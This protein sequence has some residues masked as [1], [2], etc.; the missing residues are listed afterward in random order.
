MVVRLTRK[1][2]ASAKTSVPLPQSLHRTALLWSKRDVSCRRQ[3]GWMSAAHR[4][5]HN[6]GASMQLELQHV[7][8]HADPHDVIVAQLRD[9]APRCAEVSVTPSTPPQPAALPQPASE[10]PV[11]AAPLND[12][13]GEI[14]N[15][16]PRTG[17]ARGVA[18]LIVCAGIAAAAVWNS[19]GDEAKQ[20]LSHLVPLFTGTPASTQNADTAESQ[21][22]T[23][24]ITAPQPAAAPV[25]DIATAASTATSQPAT[26]PATPTAETAL[27]QAA[28]TPELAQSIVTMAREITALKQT[29]EQL[30]AGQQQLSRDV[31]KLAEHEARR[32]SAAQVSKPAPPPQ[33]QRTSTQTAVTR[34]VQPASAQA[35]PQ[36]PAY[37]QTAAQREAYVSPPAPMQLPPQPGDTS[38]PRPP[39]PLR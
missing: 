26:A 24:Q 19:Y 13:A 16:A 32:K 12:N 3:I 23:S 25:Q 17:F 4:T 15:P 8:P 22:A 35:S 2:Y 30:Q 1:N 31:A 39:M 38:A 20:R 18:G 21:D 11:H 27:P 37:P 29:V 7:D 33:P 5:S 9:L 10:P 36:G 14:R 28:L 6:Y 34:S